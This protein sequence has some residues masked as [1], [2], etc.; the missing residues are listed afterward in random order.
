MA[1][2]TGCSASWYELNISAPDDIVSCCCY[3]G[4]EKDPWNDDVVDLE[5][6]WNSPRMQAI[7]KINSSA[8]GPSGGCAGCYYFQNRGEGAQYFADLLN[9][10]ES[11]LT[12]AQARNWRMAVEEYQAGTVQVN[13][14]PLRYYV[15]FGFGCNITCIMCHQV[16]RRKKNQRQV[17][18]DTLLGWKEHLSSAIDITVIGGEPFALVEAIKFI[19]AVVHDP[20]LDNVQLTICTNGTLHHKHLDYLVN[21]RKLQLAISL[22]TIG[23]EFERIRVGANW[24]EIERNILEF[25][26]TGK[27]LGL[28]WTVQSPCLL[29]KTAIPRLVDYVDW[30]ITHNIT[31][32]FYDFIDARGIEE[33]FQSENVVAH[34][35][36]L[37]SVPGWE[38]Y[39]D[40]AIEKLLAN[41]WTGPA[42]QL[43]ILKAS[44]KSNRE[45][46]DAMNNKARSAFQISRWDRLFRV[47]A[48]DVLS[49]LETS[50]YGPGR[51]GA[52]SRSNTDT[53]FKPTHLNDHLAT[54]YVDVSPAA[55]EDSWVRVR[56]T[57]PDN[58]AHAERCRFI[59]QD[60]SFGS[61]T[62]VETPNGAEG[63]EERYFE[64]SPSVNRIRLVLNVQG[65]PAAYLPRMLSIDV[66]STPRRKV[67]ELVQLRA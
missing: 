62:A 56:C 67:I 42:N 58:A 32:G 14:R 3:Y 18:A 40:T 15:N 22:D 43:S 59:V 17:K 13:A 26:E 53:V 35:H 28:E 54:P 21:K 46:L 38:G 36:L 4:G 24:K 41:N 64:L 31:T 7:R 50:I 8:S 1:P 63:Q 45:R 25:I 6:Y 61:L 60:G 34:P 23:E 30:C 16:P 12:P 49:R 9:M 44:I 39:I 19:K 5:S 65:V 66:G 27:R 29:L 10:Q 51:E 52:F 2:N 47:D 48:P 55:D 57:W 11:Q 33:T 37:D 20:E